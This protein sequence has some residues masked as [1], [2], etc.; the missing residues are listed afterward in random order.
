MVIQAVSA[1]RPQEPFSPLS[2]KARYD[3]K[4]ICEPFWSK[5]G[6]KKIIEWY[7]S[8]W[9]NFF[10]NHH[11]PN[12][13]EQVFHIKGLKLYRDVKTRELV[14]DLALNKTTQVGCKRVKLI[15]KLFADG[16]VKRVV[17]YS[18]LSRDA[19]DELKFAADLRNEL[20][21]RHNLGHIPSIFP[22]IRNGFY[23]AKGGEEKVRYES[24][25]FDGNLLGLP[26]FTD[27]K[28][29]LHIFLDAL[30]ALEK[31]HAHDFIHR[32]FSPENIFVQ[33]KRG[34]LANLGF[35]RQ[36]SINV[37]YS[38]VGNLLYKPSGAHYYDQK[39]DM[40]S[41]G[42]SLLQMY[43]SD[44][45]KEF[46]DNQEKLWCPKP[47]NQKAVENNWQRNIRRLQQKLRDPNGPE[48]RALSQ[49][50]AELIDSDPAKRFT[51]IKAIARLLEIIYTKM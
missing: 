36:I 8:G 41:V 5:T 27:K 47:I 48:P 15:C 32:D 26:S 6:V 51:C 35:A 10:S 23:I 46:C 38:P 43:R 2:P 45:W 31:M 16:T 1:S 49:L 28:M 24:P 25:V 7:E 39:G 33:G 30:D 19:G 29:S 20:L 13:W 3:L 4:Q 9:N 11:F 42:A 17:H 34:F 37:S 18:S 44:L 21:A 50:I 22:L 14:A 12:K 40:F